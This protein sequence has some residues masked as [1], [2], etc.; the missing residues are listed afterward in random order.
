MFSGTQ[1]FRARSLLVKSVAIVAVAASLGLVT[2][3]S[4]SPA[5]TPHLPGVGLHTLLDGGTIQVGDKLFADFSISG[6]DAAGVTVIGIEEN[7]NYGLRL[8]GAF[9]AFGNQT[10]DIL[11]GFSV[12]ATDPGQLISGVHLDF[13]GAILIGNGFVS[14]VETAATPGGEQMLVPPLAVIN[15]PAILSAYSDLVSPQEKIFV[16][17]NIV[18]QAGGDAP[19]HK[20]LSQDSAINAVKISYIDQLFVQIPEPGTAVLV[21]AG[22]LGVA[23]SGRRRR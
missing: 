21:A 20:R 19:A 12:T 8:Q 2:K 3:A 14:V 17:K 1:L 22:L 18:L 16:L 4:A 15:P 5:A 13:N 6:F 7:G 9:L 11:I 10:K 23:I